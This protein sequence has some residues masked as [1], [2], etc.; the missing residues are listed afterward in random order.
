MGFLSVLKSKKDTSEGNSR[1]GRATR[2]KAKTKTEGQHDGINLSDQS[3]SQINS[4]FVLSEETKPEGIDFVV[5]SLIKETLPDDLTFEG[6]KVNDYF[7]EIGATNEFARYFRSYYAEITGGSTLAGMLDPLL[8]GSYGQADVDVA[9]HIDPID[10][11][12]ELEDIARRVRGIK[13][14]LYREMPDEKREKLR[15][16][17]SDLEARQRRLRQNIEKPF[18]VS[19][20]VVTSASDLKVL[21]KFANNMIRRF[22]G[23]DIILRSPDGKQLQA[24]KNI[25]PLS[26]NP[27][28]KEHTFSF[29]TSNLADF[30]P[31]GNGKISHNSGVIWGRDHLGRPIFYDAWD[32]TLMNR[33]AVITGGSG[34]G[35][36]FSILR[37]VHHDTLRGIRHVI[38]CPKGDYKRYI[39][40][41]GCPYIDLGVH[42]PYKINFFDVDIEE[43]NIN[44]TLVKKVNLE[45]TVIAVRAIVFRMLKILD[46][47]SL[48]G[49]AKVRIENKIRELY[50]E[51][52][53]TDHP[54]S[55]FEEHQQPQFDEANQPLFSMSKQMKRMPQIGDLYLKLKDDEETAVVAELLKN[56]TN[57]G[58]APT[59]AIFDTQSTVK[60]QDT[61]LFGFGLSELDADI[62]KPLGLFVATKWLSTKFSHKDRH[63]RK[64]MV[65]DEA[66]IPMADPETAQWLEN[67]F[68]IVRFFNTSM[69]AVTQGF[70]VFTRSEFG[71]GILKNA[72]TKLFLKQDSIDI[73]DVQKKFNLTDY[74]AEFLT[75]DAGEGL[76]IL[77]INEERSKIQVASSPFEQMLFETNPD[78]I[79]E[80]RAAYYG[81]R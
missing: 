35:K 40:E 21:K 1:S 39:E 4:N 60:I 12:D 23:Q 7:V 44:G 80:K 29:E 16:E 41:M 72:P 65:V 6:T 25:T 63:I 14:D 20:Q 78:R 55:L 54:E 31:F 53:I 13:S 24:L 38:I 69:V 33:N 15:D 77:R 17:L 59:Q 18:R 46:E 28:Y 66:Q 74:E 48:T 3:A 57:H 70:E 9:I 8:V 32:R 51:R 19:L 62:M 50:R 26:A 37:L 45:E 64:R 30:F 49:I 10:T 71:L 56:F 67:E 11:T 2:K 52:G 79:E 73:D 61:P 81:S 75:T 47:S 76:G 27:F 36:T 42:S 5:P 43:V 68:R 22:S 34:A 58:D